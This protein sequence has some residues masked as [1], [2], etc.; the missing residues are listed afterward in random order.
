MEN[1]QE[2]SSPRVRGARRGSETQPASEVV[3]LIDE[4]IAC[5]PA[6]DAEIEVAKRYGGTGDFKTRMLTARDKMLAIR[7]KLLGH[8]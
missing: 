4:A 6:T 3:V 7:S 5:L 1:E 8:D 2:N